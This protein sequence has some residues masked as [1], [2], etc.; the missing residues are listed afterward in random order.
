VQPQH[1]VDQGGRLL[2]STGPELNAAVRR[3]LA[4]DPARPSL[5]WVATTSVRLR[6]PDP[7]SFLRVL[8]SQLAKSVMVAMVLDVT[9]LDS[10]E[11]HEA[12]RRIEAWIRRQPVRLAAPD[13]LIRERATELLEGDR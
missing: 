6:S 8:A 9:A 7:A 5:L 13:D 2:L 3:W 10:A 11:V 12:V 4:L 1:I